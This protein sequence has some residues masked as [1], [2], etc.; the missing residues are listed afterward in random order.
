M[1]EREGVGLEKA[2][3]KVLTRQRDIVNNASS[4]LHL[5]SVW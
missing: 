5:V 1:A 3:F 2:T 4:E